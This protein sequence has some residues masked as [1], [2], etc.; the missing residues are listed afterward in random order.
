MTPLPPYQ[1]PHL[2]LSATEIN[3]LTALT[4]PRSQLAKLSETIGAT[5]GILGN[6]A[7]ELF[8]DHE[9]GGEEKDKLMDEMEEMA[10]ILVDANTHSADMRV[11]LEIVVNGARA[12]GRREVEPALVDEKDG[13]FGRY[14]DLLRKKK[15]EWDG[16]SNKDKFVSRLC[17]LVGKKI[18]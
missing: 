13:L 18:K 9:K 5:I 4:N 7:Y 10:R 1:A 15:T 11:T 3:K 8:P 6:S 16:L 17:D 14:E 12:V 2:P